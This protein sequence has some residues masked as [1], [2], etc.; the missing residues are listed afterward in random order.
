VI[1]LP[2]ILFLGVP[3]QAAIATNNAGAL[4]TEVG[5]LTE[6]WRKVLAN[7]KL[8]VL[9]IIPTTLGGILGTWFLL[10]I[11]ATAIKYLMVAAVVFVLLYNYFSRNKPN[12]SHTSKADYALVIVFLFLMGIYTNF[13]GLGQGTFGRIAVMSIL[14]LS[15]IQTQG[16]TSTATMPTR[17]YSLIVTSFAG[18]I[19]WPYLLTKWC[20]NFLAGKY[21]TKFVKKVPD[22]YLK[23]VLTILSVAFVIY[24]LFFY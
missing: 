22:A 1:T 2:A 12:S 9:M 23:T 5:I 4:G 10:R 3:L 13:I 14:G 19:L 7:K 15:F 18:L 20:A 17:I 24:L 11:S 21:A 16:L 6:T 8:M